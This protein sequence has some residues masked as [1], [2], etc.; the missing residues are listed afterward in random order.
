MVVLEDEKQVIV[1]FIISSIDVFKSQKDRFN[2]IGIYCCP[3]AGWISSSFN[4][5]KSIAD[6]LHNC[7]DFDVV[8]FDF[9]ELKHWEEE[10]ERET[11]TYIFEGKTINLN[12]E[13]GDEVLN[14]LFFKFLSTIALEIKNAVKEE[15]LLQ[16]LDSKFYRVF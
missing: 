8:E 11:P 14:A 10:Y 3:W 7:P 15:L 16:M 1:N 9:L 12:Y 13:L 4:I 5:D 6:T 2:S